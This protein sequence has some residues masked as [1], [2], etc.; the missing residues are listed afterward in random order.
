MPLLYIR[1]P[2]KDNFSA[3]SVSE[4]NHEGKMKRI[5]IQLNSIPRDVTPSKVCPLDSPLKKQ[6]ELL[7]LREQLLL[8]ELSEKGL[9]LELSFQLLCILFNYIS[10][11]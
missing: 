1:L 5:N 2:S 9:T 6:N 4:E 7:D 10:Y 11:W 8:S 3:S